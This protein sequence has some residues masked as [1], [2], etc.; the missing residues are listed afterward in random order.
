MNE[1]VLLMNN[2]IKKILIEWSYRLDD[3]MIDLE[4][5]THFSILREVL[6][7]MKLPS[8]V[9]IEVMGNITEEEKESFPA[10]KKDTGNVSDFSS[11]QTRDAAI[12]AGTHTAVDKKDDKVKGQDL[13]KTDT[14]T[15]TEDKA[16]TILNKLTSNRDDILAGKV[17]PPGQPGSAVQ[18]TIGGE[19][20]EE[21]AQGK[22]Q[23]ETEEEFIERQI[24]EKG[25]KPPL[26]SLSDTMKRKWL[27]IAYKKG[28]NDINELKNDPV[29][30]YNQK[31]PKGFPKAVS[32]DP[33]T[34]APVLEALK[35]KRKECEKLKN[36]SDRDECKKH[37]DNQ[38]KEFEE[39]KDTDSMLVY[40]D[41]DGRIRVEH[42]SDKSDLND[43]FMNMT[44]DTK[45]KSHQES[46]KRVGSDMGLSEE[47][48]E[49]VSTNII[50]VEQEVSDIVKNTSKL[51]HNLLK[52]K[53][54]EE[55]DNAVDNGL[56]SVMGNLSAGQ[57]GRRD[58]G[59][60]INQQIKSATR[61]AFK[62][63]G[64]KLEEI[65]AKKDK[66][67]NYSQEDIAKA[68]LLVVKENPNSP[69]RKYVEKMGDT[70]ERTRRTAEIVER[71]VRKKAEKE[72]PKPTE[73]QIQKR[74]NEETARRVNGEGYPKKKG[75][76]KQDSEEPANPISEEDVKN[77]RETGGIMDELVV[78][79]RTSKDS[80][81]EAHKRIKTT[82]IE[83]DKE[84]GFPDEEGR[85]GPHSQT[86]IGSW[87]K[88]MHWSRHFD[89][90]PWEEDG[91]DNGDEGGSINAGGKVVKSQL[92]VECI[93]EITG[94]T[95]DLETKEDKKKFW[96]WLR[97]NLRIS[98]EE[99][100]VTINTDKGEKVVG[101][102]NYR[103]GGIG[104]QKVTG[105]IGKEIQTCLKGK[106]EESGQV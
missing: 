35:E 105:Q 49:E 86:Y 63:L 42:I 88:D 9:I 20:S 17:K 34:A 10:I 32:G 16:V 61:G 80:M 21:L 50:S 73:E 77:M 95:G 7:D 67:G 47:Q 13:F 18:E 37:Y 94:Y 54:D 79:S 3:G 81:A 8:E 58:Y 91:D 2:L 6:S 68:I 65:G 102:Q 5:N 59:I 56:G 74:I 26:N 84:L 57:R 82:L 85:N 66:D 12:K 27:K 106:L 98:S 62:D 101:K 4:N 96:K 99:S 103:S 19:Y 90:P 14:S 15:E 64:N 25:D 44:I 40:Y 29:K 69:L 33:K 41:N 78:V 104:V 31:Q 71:E 11:K 92:I 76:L 22:H 46:M 30:D 89:G 100:S 75:A 24:K 87:M 23:N 72:D 55:I 38:L 83:K 43:T 97:E 39:R 28:K 36:P 70:I 48:Q 45:S 93:K 52:E 51:A 1:V 60:K 53:S